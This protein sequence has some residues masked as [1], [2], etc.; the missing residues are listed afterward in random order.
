MPRRHALIVPWDQRAP[1]MDAAVRQ[2]RISLPTVDTLDR[3]TAVA[4]RTTLKSGTVRDF[5]LIEAKNAPCAVCH[6]FAGQG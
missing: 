3:H 1:V 4:G 2:R 5:R 6:H